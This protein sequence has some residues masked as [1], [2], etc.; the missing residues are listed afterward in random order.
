VRVLLK[1]AGFTLIALAVACSDEQAGNSNG[2][3]DI[4]PA[5]TTTAP[6]VALTGRVTDAADILNP[7]QEASLSAKLEQLE[8][9]TH[10]QMVVATVPTLRGADIATFTKDLANSWGIGRKGYDDGVVILVAPNERQARIA[11][12]RGMEKTLTND[13]CRKIIQEQMLPRF[14]EGDLPGGIE[15]GADAVIAKLS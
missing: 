12:G 6:V 4:T 2:M 5:I 14:R 13:L 10:H 11:V 8:R 1:L 15:A 9:A 7:E 3:G